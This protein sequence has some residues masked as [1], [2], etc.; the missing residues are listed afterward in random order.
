MCN[1]TSRICLHFCPCGRRAKIKVS[2]HQAVAINSPPD[3]CDLHYSNLGRTPKQKGHPFGCPFVLEVPARFELADQS[4][5]DSCL[6]TWLRYHMKQGTRLRSSLFFGAGDEARTR[7]L[8]LGKVALYRMS[9]AR[10]YGSFWNRGASGRN[11]TNDTWIF[12]PLLYQLSYRGIFRAEPKLC[13]FYLATRN[14]L[15]PSTSS[16]TGWRANRLHHRAKLVE[17]TGLEPVTPCL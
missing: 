4:F 1:A 9:Y 11:R 14:G 6:T 7:Y 10:I 2:L 12:S 3:C 15:E 16:V 5:A 17:T 8:H 13:T